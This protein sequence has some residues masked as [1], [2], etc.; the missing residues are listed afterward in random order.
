MA[1]QKIIILPSGVSG[2]YSR[3]T[4]FRWDRTTREASALIDLYLDAATAVSGSPL[5][6]IVAKLRLSGDKFDLYLSTAALAASANDVVAQLYVAAKAEP[7][8]SDH[9][10]TI[11]A[12][13]IDV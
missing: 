8:I 1:L 4:H 11:F 5:R 3:I 10:A 9:G 2:D 7:V 12:D 13:A 6:P